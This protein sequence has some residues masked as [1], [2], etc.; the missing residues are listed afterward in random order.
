M[1]GHLEQRGKNV[2]KI[3]L[4]LGENADGKRLRSA[5]TFHGTKREAEE[6]M[7][8]LLRKLHTGTYV[9]E[10][11]MT[12]KQYLEHWLATYAKPTVGERTYDRYEEIVRQHLEPALGRHKLSKLRPLH[13]S[14]YYAEALADGR[15][16]RVRKDER[17][18][19]IGRRRCLRPPRR[20]SQRRP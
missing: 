14:A 15:V 17:V 9:D 18:H 7:T 1:K 5:P 2:W 11:R 13:I 16:R 10:T 4:E 19:S 3:V 12:V 20:A 6:E 8:R